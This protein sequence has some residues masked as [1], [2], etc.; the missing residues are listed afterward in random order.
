MDSGFPAK[1]LSV[2]ASISSPIGKLGDDRTHAAGTSPG[3]DKQAHHWDTPP[4][5]V[6]TVRAGLLAC[7]SSRL[8]RLP[9]EIHQWHGATAARRSQL[10][11]QRR[12]WCS[13]RSIAPASLLASEPIDSEDPDGVKLAWRR[14]RV[15]GA[16]LRSAVWTQLGGQPDGRAGTFS[17]RIHLPF[18][19]S[20]RPLASCEGRTIHQ[21][22]R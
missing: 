10:R 3:G 12:S 22:R 14:H 1:P 17:C 19:C 11:G 6:T 9:G 16:R 7:G 8:S 18:S 15:N 21:N 4:M 20:L 5:D 13:F 2:M